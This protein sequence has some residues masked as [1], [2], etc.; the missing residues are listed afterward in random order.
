[1]GTVRLIAQASGPAGTP[2]LVAPP[3]PE[4]LNREGA[5]PPEP[6]LLA[7]N[8][9]PRRFRVR[10]A[11]QPAL[12]GQS[13]SAYLSPLVGENCLPVQP[14]ENSPNR[15]P[16]FQLSSP[17]PSNGAPGPAVSASSPSGWEMKLPKLGILLSQFPGLSACRPQSG[18]GS[19]TQSSGLMTQDHHPSAADRGRWWRRLKSARPRIDGGTELFGL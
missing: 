9:E 18:M 13:L 11:H 16:K 19:P 17:G 3:R 12:G 6:K 14:G 15:E 10:S 1:L 5:R 7:T 4:R 2:T 8:A